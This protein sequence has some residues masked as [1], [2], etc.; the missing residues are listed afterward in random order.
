[1]NKKPLSVRIKERIEHCRI[2][3]GKGW[4]IPPD[5]KIKASCPDCRDWFVV[6]R[7]VIKLEKQLEK[8]KDDSKAKV[9]S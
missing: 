9:T 2:C 7:C 8:Y 1:M 4:W 5:L 3:K 6:L